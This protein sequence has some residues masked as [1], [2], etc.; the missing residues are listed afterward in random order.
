MIFLSG[1]RQHRLSCI[2]P[3]HPM[4]TMPTASAQSF[5]QPFAAKYAY[6]RS[7]FLSLS[8]SMHA[9]KSLSLKSCRI[10]ASFHGQYMIS[11]AF[12]L[13]FSRK[14]QSLLSVTCREQNSAFI[15]WPG[16]RSQSLII[17]LTEISRSE[18][19]NVDILLTSST[20]APGTPLPRHFFPAS[21]IWAVYRPRFSTTW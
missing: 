5:S 19:I 13:Y 9:I 15:D 16:Y 21:F 6:S 1:Y 4:S 20:S 7:R 8:A 3:F 18:G 2:V 11:S 12:I 17:S 10:L 14:A